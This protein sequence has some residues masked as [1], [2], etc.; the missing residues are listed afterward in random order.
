MT[1]LGR[2]ETFK[3]YGEIKKNRV[4]IMIDPRSTL[5]IIDKRTM[6]KLGLSIDTR[7]SF[8]ISTLG[9]HQIQ[10]EGVAHQIELQVEDYMLKGHFYITEVGGVDVVL[11]IQWLISI[12]TYNTNYLEGFLKFWERGREY[13][14]KVIPP[15]E[16]KIV[17]SEQMNKIL[18]KGHFGF[19]AWLYKMEVPSDTTINHP[20]EV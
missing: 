6:K 10:C 11:K 20:L 2:L 16:N 14:I 15:K 8:P 9:Q 12:G 17:N 19:I 18:R 13:T 1:G 3:T 7:K 4:L 5:N